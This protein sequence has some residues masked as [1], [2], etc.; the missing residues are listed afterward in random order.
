MANYFYNF[1]TTYY[2]NTDDNTDLDVVTDITKRIGFEQEFK[3]NSAAYFKIVV[4]D[5][6][7]PEI[8]AHKFYDDVEKHWII[9]MMNDII[10]PQFDWP[11]KEPDLYKF[12][13]SKYANNASPEQTGTDWA[14][15]NTQSYFKIETKT[16]VQ[17][18][19]ITTEK[20][21]LDANTYANVTIS[22]VSYTLNDGY[23]LNIDVT[24]ETQSYF[25]YEIESNDAK[26]N[27]I[28][29]RP[30]FVGIAINELKNIFTM[31]Q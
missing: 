26:R 31:S 29:L 6:D 28:L 5:D 2:I 3:K 20:I 24:K 10:D 22:S 25:D 7:T 12:I 23:Q 8:L 1:P 27:I 14:Q 17:T 18:N 19:Q 13:E 21:A 11:M 16:I 15:N 9:L 4:T 30:E